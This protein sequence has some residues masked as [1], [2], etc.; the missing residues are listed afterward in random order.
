MVAISVTPRSI[1]MTR[2][3]LSKTCPLM[4]R[5]IECI[6][7]FSNMVRKQAYSSSVNRTMTHFFAGSAL[8]GLP[9]FLCLSGVIRSS[10]AFN[11][12]WRRRSS[13]VFNV[14]RYPAGYNDLFLPFSLCGGRGS[15]LGLFHK[16]KLPRGIIGCIRVRDANHCHTDANHCHGQ[17]IAGS[18]GWNVYELSVEDMPERKSFFP[19]SLCLYNYSKK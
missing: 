18:W 13:F 1:W 9:G 2:N 15:D 5:A 10:I 14:D 12:A 17:N 3:A 6:P 8:R 4:K 19:G 16:A 11:F 7:D